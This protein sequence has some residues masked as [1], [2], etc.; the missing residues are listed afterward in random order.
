MPI[1]DNLFPRTGQHSLMRR[2]D[3]IRGSYNC[4]YL[5][6][7]TFVSQYIIIYRV[8]WFMMYELHESRQS[9]ERCASKWRRDEI[10]VLD[11]LV[12]PENARYVRPALGVAYQIRHI[13][14]TI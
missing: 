13:A 9:V 1:N 2:N 14:E 7:D 4:R 3:A 6:E 11:F 10:H 12:P 5:L 8:A